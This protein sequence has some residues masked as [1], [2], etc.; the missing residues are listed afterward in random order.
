MS[1]S[2]LLP[3]PEACRKQGR[4]KSLN[5]QKLSVLALTNGFFH[6]IILLYSLNTFQPL[7]KDTI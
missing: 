6:V 1:E 4:N 7:N 3:E 5:G 2:L